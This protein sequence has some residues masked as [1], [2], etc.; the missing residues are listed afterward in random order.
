[1]IQQAG[2]IKATEVCENEVF[3]MSPE[4]A[5]RKTRLSVQVYDVALLQAS[6]AL[7]C[8]RHVAH[9]QTRDISHTHCLQ[10]PRRQSVLR[11]PS[12]RGKLAFILRVGTVSWDV[13]VVEGDLS[14][15]LDSSIAS[16]KQV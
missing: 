7:D 14:T 4:A 13:G 15:N 12:R 1:M 3:E 16:N 9:R 8:L 11:L 6:S 10:C 2:A 5:S